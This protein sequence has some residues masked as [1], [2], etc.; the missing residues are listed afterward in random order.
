MGHA[1]TSSGNGLSRILTAWLSLVL[2]CASHSVVLAETFQWLQYGPDGLEMRLITEQP[3]C[4]VA[5]ID[6]RAVPMRVR[7][8]A[9]GAFS[10]G[11]CAAVVPSDAKSVSVGDTAFKLP[12]TTPRRVAL[13][14]DTGCR[15]KSIYI[16]ACNDP[17]QWPFA[18]VAATIAAQDPDLIVHVGDYH[19]RET[20]C[21]ALFSGCAGSPFGDT[22]EVW[23]ADFFTPAAPLLAKAPWV[24]VRG[25]HEECARAGRGWSRMLEPM[26]FDSEA[27]CNGPSAAFAVPF[28]NL[29]LAV[30]DVATAT[31]P[32]VARGEIS[33]FRAQYATLG[34]LTAGPV[35]LLQH[36][37]IWSA[38]G[39]IAGF[40]LGDNK[41]LAAAANGLIPPNVELM[42]SGHHHI[43]Q[44]LQYA[45]DLPVQIVAGHGGDYL[46]TGTSTN[47]AGWVINGMTVKAGLH[48]VG[49]FGFAMLESQGGGEWRLTNYD[50]AGVVEQHCMI[51]S[52]QIACAEK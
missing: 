9:A 20:E 36:R 46:N 17:A 11:V 2:A 15:L 14:G 35:W 52:R 28:P 10:V 47:P 41:T 19:Y 1:A 8:A 6:G 5:S 26:P 18:Q 51:K 45:Q 27:G 3:S 32:K 42:I 34:K 39:T 23:R 13:V 48:K 38:G 12:P 7:A 21:P 40:P 37:P 43:F 33:H 44:V 31:E 16:Q 29:T 25:N 24:F 49:K 30:L 22:W 50:Q 4:P